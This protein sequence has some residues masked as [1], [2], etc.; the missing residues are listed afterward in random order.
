[1]PP[2]HTGRSRVEQSWQMA[3][4]ALEWI[5]AHELPVLA[6]LLI[7]V[8]GAWGFIELADD[9]LEGD[10]Q[11]I[12]ERVMVWMRSPADLS[13]PIGPEWLKAAA[14]DLTALGGHWV[15][16]LVVVI[17]AGFLWMKRLYGAMCL[18]VVATVGG[19]LASHFLKLL[20]ERQRPSVVPHLTEVSSHSFP[21]GHSMV[22]AVVY[23]TL[24]VLLARLVDERRLK[25]YFLVIALM[26][27]FVIGLTRIYLGVHYPTDVLA[28]WSAGLVWAC[29]CWLVARWLQRRGAVEAEHEAL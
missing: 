5:G 25:A 13:T 11:Q 6:M 9:V 15:L 17:V 8:A 18:V 26:L 14:L 27:T 23:L 19:S 3:R 28:G 21:S 24:G 4:R 1:M 7:V 10:T 22:S 29:A 16:T 2:K 12:D 20:F